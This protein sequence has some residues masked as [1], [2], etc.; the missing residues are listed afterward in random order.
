MNSSAIA[1]M[2]ARSVLRRLKE[3][4]WTMVL[5]AQCLGLRASEIMGFKWGDVDF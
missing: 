3:S 5:V 1:D 2:H 4:D